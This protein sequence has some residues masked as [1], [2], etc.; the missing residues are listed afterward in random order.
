MPK[1]HTNAGWMAV[2]LIAA[3][4]LP[5]AYMGAYYAVFEIAVIDEW[6]GGQPYPGYRIDHPIVEAIFWPS[7]RVERRGLE[8]VMTPLFSSG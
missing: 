3:V 7:Q 1:P 6:P 4:L 2:I 8:M 5:A